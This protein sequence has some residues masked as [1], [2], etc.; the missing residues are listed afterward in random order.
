MTCP[1][2][3]DSCVYELPTCP[4]INMDMI[5]VRDNVVACSMYD[6]VRGNNE[7]AKE[8]KLCSH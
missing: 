7:W 1:N 5:W 6:K 3:C 8:L 4:S 2:L